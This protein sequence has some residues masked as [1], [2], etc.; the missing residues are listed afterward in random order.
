MQANV[1]SYLPSDENAVTTLLR[2]LCALKPIREAV[3]RLF[4]KKSFGADDVEFEDVWTQFSIG[5][6]ILDMCLKTDT[7][8][9]VVEIK[10]SDWRCLTANQ[11]QSYLGW[12]VN[13]SVNHKFFV[14][15]VPPDYAYRQEYE[16]R[17]AVFCTGNP[18]HGIRFVEITWLDVCTVLEEAG[19]SATSVY[20]RDF[21]NLLEEWYVPAPITFT[22]NELS[23]I[24]MYD[25]NAATAI[26]KMFEFVEQIASE[27]E[28]AGFTVS[29]NFPR[30]WWTSEH[31]L[32]IKCGNEDVLFLGIWSGFWKDYG[33]PLCIGVNNRKWTPAVIARFQLMFQSYV[34]Y[35]PNGA[36]PYSTKGID[37]LFLM[38]DAVRDVSNWLLQG[39][40]KGIC[41]LITE[42]QQSTNP[43][44]GTV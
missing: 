26:C 5:G 28:R 31:G 24:T 1:L 7:L 44:D 37:Q 11:P 21:Q 38:G 22:L 29:R 41:D 19:L 14:F 9:A 10:V 18:N 3:V 32:Y 34:I 17:K 33:Y 25:K 12:L 36:P 40:L 30:R 6:A 42:N 2:A 35:P 16:R 4:T 8:R 23:Q 43:L 39:Y 27:F 15:L 20:A 13:Q